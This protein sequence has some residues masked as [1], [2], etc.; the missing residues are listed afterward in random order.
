MGTDKERIHPFVAK[1][2]EQLADGRI[3][4]REFLRLASLMGVSAA[5]AWILAACGAPTTPAPAAPT[6]APA[7]A[8]I[9]RGG[10][11]KLGMYLQAI[12]HPAR[13]SWTEGS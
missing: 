3:S 9:K 7:A 5:S 13:L 6:T 12:D 4:R 10:V 8:T 11:L 2:Q 1:A